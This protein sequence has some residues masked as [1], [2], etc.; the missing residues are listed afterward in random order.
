LRQ[1]DGDPA[2]RR[3]NA[4]APRRCERPLCWRRALGTACL[5]L[6]APQGL[7]GS[8][9]DE[10]TSRFRRL[11]STWDGTLDRGRSSPNFGPSRRGRRFA[12]RQSSSSRVAPRQN[13]Y[14]MKWFWSLFGATT[15]AI[16]PPNARSPRQPGGLSCPA[17]PRISPSIGGVPPHQRRPAT[18]ERPPPVRSA[19]TV[20][21]RTQWP[22]PTGGLTRPSMARLLPIDQR[23]SLERPSLP[24]ISPTPNDH[25]IDA[26]PASATPASRPSSRLEPTPTPSSN[27]EPQ[28]AHHRHPPQQSYAALGTELSIESKP[29]ARGQAGPGIR[30]P[31]RQ[32]GAQAPFVSPST[33]RACPPRSS[34]AK[35][36]NRNRGQS[37]RRPA[38]FELPPKR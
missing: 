28:P 4:H 9:G 37:H 6:R 14:Q 31:T 15:L 29:G 8:A 2:I 13:T 5:T 27:S 20:R 32:A 1:T 21:R 24:A 18:A 35:V 22:A 10:I 33:G 3:T 34:Q 36:F 23:P 17:T 38:N 19:T 30:R 11:R 7:R 12:F 16:D 26:Q 25:A